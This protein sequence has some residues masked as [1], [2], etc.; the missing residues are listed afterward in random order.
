[1]THLGTHLFRFELAAYGGHEARN[2]YLAGKERVRG[3]RHNET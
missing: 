2:L 3:L 1:M